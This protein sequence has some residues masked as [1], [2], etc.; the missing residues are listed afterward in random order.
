MTINCLLQM[1]ETLHNEHGVQEL[2]TRQLNQDCVENLFS[3]IRSKCGARDNP[4]AQQFRA[5]RK[6]VCFQEN[7]D[8]KENPPQ[9]NERTAQRV[10][11]EE[12]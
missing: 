2:R 10:S 9:N 1:W 4:D 6:K 7:I 3:I 8:A 11:G 5:A 12:S